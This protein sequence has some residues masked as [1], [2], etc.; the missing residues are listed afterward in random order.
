[1]RSAIS[2]IEEKQPASRRLELKF[3]SVLLKKLWDMSS[4]N[5]EI[6]VLKD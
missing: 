2:A 1:M 4:H 5:K 6:F 3:V